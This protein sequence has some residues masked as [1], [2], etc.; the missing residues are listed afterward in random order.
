MS[1]FCRLRAEQVQESCAYYR[2]TC[3]QTVLTTR[4]AKEEVTSSHDYSASK[5]TCQVRPFST[6]Q[7]SCINTHNGFKFETV[8]SCESLDMRTA[9]YWR[10][11]SLQGAQNPFSFSTVVCFHEFLVLTSEVE[12]AEAAGITLF[13]QGFSSF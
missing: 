2:Q 11:C 3:H 9:V 7:S 12:K 10:P 1:T 6:N 8:F 13:C 5:K 4:T